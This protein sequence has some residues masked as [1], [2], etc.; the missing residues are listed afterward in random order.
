MKPTGNGEGQD[1]ER[2]LQI[3][4]EDDVAG[5]LHDAQDLTHQVL[6]SDPEDQAD[7]CFLEI[8]TGA[9]GDDA[10]SFSEM[11]V[12]MYIEWAS[13]SSSS[14]AVQVDEW[15]PAD[16]G[17]RSARLRCTGPAVMGWLAGEAGVHRL[18]RISPFDASGRRHTSFARVLVFPST[19]NVSGAAVADSVEN[20]LRD[21]AALRVDTFRSSGKGGQSVNTT[22]SAVRMTHLPT[23]IAA[24]YQGERSQLHNRKR[25]L[26]VLRAKLA[27]HVSL[28]L[29]SARDEH[30][31]DVLVNEN[32]FGGQFRSYV[33]DTGVVNDH[34]TGFKCGDAG[35]VL[36]RGQIGP[37]LVAGL[38]PPENCFPEGGF[39][40]F[41]PAKL[42]PKSTEN[43]Y[44]FSRPDYLGGS[45]FSPAKFGRKS[46]GTN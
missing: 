10:Q 44:L 28:E 17:I 19:P 35:R 37:L 30:W 38:R 25:C 16:N 39:S 26:S 29:T 36:A 46:S 31:R 33:L 22:D 27:A 12:N 6:L 20:M 5:I 15:N 34:R 7:E 32:S 8:Y 43:N 41:T 14:Y 21:P 40:L 23:G 2:K 24:S 4:L 11:L 13:S 45:L 3:Q 9:G 18:V 42:G 1:K